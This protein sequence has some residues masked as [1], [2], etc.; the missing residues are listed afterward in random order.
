M[1][2]LKSK[3]SQLGFDYTRFRFGFRTGLAA[4]LSLLIAWSL[5]LEHPQWSA[6]TVWAVSQPTRGLLLEKAAYRALGTLIGTVIGML[7]VV[8]AGDNVLQLALGLTFWVAAC[9]YVGNLLHGLISY[10][11]ILAGYSASMV[12][13]LSRTPDAWLP[14]GIDRLL[15]VFVGVLTAL[16]IG[17]LFT[18]SRAEQTLVNQFRRQTAENLKLLAEAYQ[19]GSLQHLNSHDRL[20]KLALLESQLVDHG[21]GSPAAHRSAKTIRQVLNA[22]MGLFAQLEIKGIIQSDELSEY[23]HKCSQALISNKTSRINAHLQDTLT[24]FDH[25][26]LYPYWHE[27]VDATRARLEFRDTGKTANSVRQL[28]VLLHRDWRGAKQA[29]IRTLVTMSIIS[30]IW[31]YTGWFQVAYLLLGASVMLTLFSTADNPAKTMYY[32][33]LGQSAGAITALLMQAFI[34]P[35]TNSVLTMLLSLMPIILLA[36]LPMSHNKTAAGAM[37]FNLVFLLLMQ[38]ALHYQFNVSEAT[39]IALAVITAPLVAMASYR[40]MFP[41]D[42]RSRQQQ[43]L[44][45]LEHDLKNLNNQLVSTN[46]LQ[47]YR[48]RL[49]HRLF[50]LYAMSGSLGV[51]AKVIAAQY[52]LRVQHQVSQ[53]E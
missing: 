22:Q 40:L 47:R 7:L 18:Y 16:L 8:T 3:F 45:S 34:W 20:S 23:L 42:L 14:L 52:L 32:V 35:Q 2:A 15:T 19:S 27:F 36:G 6:M 4:C 25:A 37:D 29:A 12:A 9:V 1:T 48:A 21:S 46:Q 11:A 41:T 50:K 44:L 24:N 30:C 43:L 38:P 10:G 51:E 13:L 28:S 17:W 33:F 31:A 26:P 39:S 53:H 5:G 49:Y